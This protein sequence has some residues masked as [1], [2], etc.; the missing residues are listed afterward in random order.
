MVRVANLVRH[1][2]RGRG[3]L[4]A[5]TTEA[6]TSVGRSRCERLRMLIRIVFVGCVEKRLGWTTRGLLI[7]LSLAIP[8]RFLCLRT[9]RAIV[10]A[11]M[12]VAGVASS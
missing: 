12:G 10:V 3:V 5:S 7:M 11:V 6:T 1:G 4:G 2:G 9:G 8:I